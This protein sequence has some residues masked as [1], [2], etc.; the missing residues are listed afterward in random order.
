MHVLIL[1]SWYPRF[2]G[3]IEGS[4]FREQALALA[5]SGLKVGVVFPDLRGPGRFIRAKKKFGL[6]V[7]NDEGLQEVRSHGFNW[8]PRG[9]ASFHWLWTKHAKRALKHYIREF[10]KPD[11]VHV[12]SMLPSGLA[13]VWFQRLHN[14]PFVVTEHATS[15]L[16]SFQS[17]IIM[18]QCRKIA[19]FSKINISVSEVLGNYL[20]DLLGNK[21]HYV[22]NIVADSFL[23]HPLEATNNGN[24]NLI[25]VAFL[26]QNKRM[27]LVINALAIL[28]GRNIDVSLSI[29][30]DGPE[31]SGLEAQAFQ[32]NISDRVKFLGQVSRAELPEVMS[33]ASIL[34]SASEV[35]TF[36]VTLVE[37]LALGLP[38]VATPSGGPQTI[39]TP[40][41][42]RL[43]YDWDSTNIADAIEDVIARK[44]QFS[45][46]DLREHCDQLYSEKVICGALTSIYSDVLLE[47]A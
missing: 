32:L 33:R 9:E 6:Q 8:F 16:K 41:V 12:H 7:R 1:P 4:F 25:S 37:G 35:E 40:S 2:E 31:K 19:S 23:N 22:P 21:W 11:I 24:T 17:P 42:G 36:G 14:V 46:N 5:N 27:D 28:V 44:D 43:V 10:G 15:F 34:V 45:P 38:I 30:G 18:K 20:S 39:V 13:A 26:R 47:R 3:D 29:V